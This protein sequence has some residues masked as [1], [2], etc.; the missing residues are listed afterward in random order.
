MG[1]R[2]NNYDDEDFFRKNNLSLG[3]FS[4]IVI[5]HSDYLLDKNYNGMLEDFTSF[6]AL[7]IFK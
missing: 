1:K 5:C 2:E 7:L 4:H 6:L 3:N